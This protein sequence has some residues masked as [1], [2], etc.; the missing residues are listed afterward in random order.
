V[1]STL[2][3][4]IP[5]GGALAKISAVRPNGLRGPLARRFTAGSGHPIVCVG[6][7]DPEMSYPRPTD[8]RPD[9]YRCPHG[10]SPGGQRCQLMEE[11]DTPAHMARIAGTLRAWS[12]DGETA[13]ATQ[14]V[15]R[16]R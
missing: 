2:A 1:R 9:E 15:T 3:R 12:D 6:E 10:G 4:S 16:R 14:P 7:E 11:H 5:P 8:W 13:T